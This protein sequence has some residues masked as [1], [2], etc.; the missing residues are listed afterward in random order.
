MVVFGAGS[1][2]CS[3]VSSPE[4]LILFRGVQGFGA[5]LIMPATLSILTNVFRDDAERARGDRLWAGVSGPGR[6]S[7]ALAGGFLLEH[8]WWGSIFLVNV[9]LVAVAIVAALLVVPESL[10]PHAPGLD[11]VGTVLSAGGL[12]S[13]LYDDHR[14][15]ERRVG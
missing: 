10:D 13:L 1:F 14:G 9:P 5:A 3:Q 2:A 8:F 6:G 11:L 7:G 12:L 4:S 15:P